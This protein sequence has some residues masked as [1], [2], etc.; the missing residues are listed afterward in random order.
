VK[1]ADAEA[2]AE[3]FEDLEADLRGFL[4]STRPRFWDPE[5]GVA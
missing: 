5:E 1:F 3:L 2:R 4:E